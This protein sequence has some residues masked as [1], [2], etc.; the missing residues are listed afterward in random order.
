MQSRAC[1]NRAMVWL[2]V[3]AASRYL[4]GPGTKQVGTQPMEKWPNMK[5]WPEEEYSSRGPVLTLLQEHWKELCFLRRGSHLVCGS[6]WS[7]FG[8]GPSSVCIA[9]GNGVL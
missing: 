6:L 3:L 2:A 5:M 7:A 4:G 9:E 8:E 1:W